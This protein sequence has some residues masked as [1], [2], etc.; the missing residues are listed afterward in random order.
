MPTQKKSL[1]KGPKTIKVAKTGKLKSNAGKGSK[2]V[3]LALRKAG[4]SALKYVE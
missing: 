4:G 2:T 1:V 3:N